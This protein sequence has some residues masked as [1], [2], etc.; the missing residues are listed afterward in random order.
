M[1]QEEAAKLRAELKVARVK[2]QALIEGA[3]AQEKT[4][5]AVNEE[6][7]VGF[8]WGYMDLKRRLALDHP[9]QDL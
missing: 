8:L 7:Q 1:A 9:D 4:E 2:V 5:R 3:T 6:F